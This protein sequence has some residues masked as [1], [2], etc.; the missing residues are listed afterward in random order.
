MKLNHIDLPVKD[1]HGVR[2]FLE[3]HFGF[4]CIFERDDGLTVLLDED[5]L[6]LTLSTIP[7][8]ETLHYPTGFHVGFNLDSQDELF[9]THGQ[10]I[11]A[12]AP[13]ADWRPGKGSARITKN[14]CL[15]MLRSRIGLCL[16]GM[17]AAPMGRP[18]PGGR[19]VTLR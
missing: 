3:R 10:L 17:S 2:T 16:S 4:R 6:A 11:A 14:R 18:P 1:I 7:A 12:G 8:N 15:N 19:S 5:G 13:I 9:E